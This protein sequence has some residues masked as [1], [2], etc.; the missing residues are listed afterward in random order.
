MR[1][2]LTEEQISALKTKP[3]T[4]SSETI[5]LALKLRF[6]LG[7]HGYNYLRN[8]N[9]PLPSYSTLNKRLRN[10][11]MTFGVFE[12]LFAPLKCKVQALD[13]LDRVCTMSIDEMEVSG[14]IEFDKYKNSFCGNITLG[15]SQTIGNHI[16]VILIRGVKTAWKQVIA[17]EVTGPSTKGILQKQ[18]IEKCVKFAELCGLRVVSLSS[19]MGSNNRAMWSAFGVEVTRNENQRN[20][21]FT[22]DSNDIHVVPDVCHLI[23]NMKNT[24]LNVGLYLPQ[25][26]VENEDLPS[27]FV[28]GKYIVQLWHSEIEKDKELRL[29]HH[30]KRDDVEP[31]HFNK[32]NVGSAVRFFSVKTAAALELAVKLKSLPPEALTTAYFC[33]LIEQWF[34]ICCSKISKAGIT[35]KNKSAKFEFLFRFVKIFQNISIGNGWKPLNTGMIM[36]TLS[37][38]RITEQLLNEGYK[39]VLLHRFTQDAVENIFSQIRRKAGS[40]PSALQCLKALKLITVSQFISDIKR[41]SYFNDSDIFLIDNLPSK[42][43]KPNTITVTTSA[44]VPVSTVSSCKEVATSCTST[45]KDNELSASNYFSL[46]PSSSLVMPSICVSASNDRVPEFSFH[47]VQLGDLQLTT[48]EKNN[49]FNIGGSTTNAML[50]KNVCDKCKQFLNEDH[51][52]ETYDT[53][54][55][56]LNLGGLKKPNS[57]VLTLICNCE[58]LYRQNKQHILH[59][60][61]KLLINKIVQHIC[62]S[63][64]VCCN[65]KEKVVKHFFTVRS[66]AVV[67]FNK[68]VKKRCKMYGTASEKKRKT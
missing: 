54:V 64:P 1:S 47:T 27:N 67:D 20:I 31:S 16:T 55:H 48:Y 4:W 33:R 37:L 35:A 14:S 68:N 5:I 59:N 52:D 38:C 29:L 22:V 34:S 18:V 43:C 41:S 26:L 50:K 3:T 65:L 42:D 9:Y 12:S 45:A 58:V 19:D 24:I 28:S 6:S 49:L 36:S 8:T 13:P 40:C 61:A 60:D 30:L 10:L 15:D 44:S 63:F 25:S 46:P 7:I 56:F 66:Y 32:M 21:H 17:C 51:S 57:E 11:E 53:F 39:F 62:P 2:F 23:K